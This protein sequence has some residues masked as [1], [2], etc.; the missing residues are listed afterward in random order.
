MDQNLSS[1]PFLDN[2]PVKL[3]L[4]M[5]RT[6]KSV[7]DVVDTV[8]WLVAGG[9]RQNNINSDDAS[10]TLLSTSSNMRI[11]NKCFCMTAINV[12]DRCFHLVWLMSLCDANWW[13][14]LGMTW[15]IEGAHMLAVLLTNRSVSFAVF[16]SFTSFAEFLLFY[17]AR[18]FLPSL[19]SFT[20]FVLF[21]RVCPLLPSL[22]SFTEFGLFHRVCPLLSSLSSSTAHI[23][24]HV[25]PL[26]PSTTC[27]LSY[28]S[29]YTVK[30]VVWRKGISGGCGSFE[31]AAADICFESLVLTNCSAEVKI[32]DYRQVVAGSG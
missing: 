2:F 1:T 9:Y 31:G 11:I 20:K 4:A 25:H 23:L 10:R 18:P 17:R 7:F 12:A 24:F 6:P 5:F 3:S 21:Y 15:R 27:L 29:A 14:W 30:F 28:V 13:R 16:I 8:E 32:F 19:S 26:S 22:F